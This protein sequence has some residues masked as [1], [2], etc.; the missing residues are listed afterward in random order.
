[1]TLDTP[2]GT[3]SS[4]E[5]ADTSLHPTPPSHH[6]FH[7]LDGLRGIAAFMVVLYHMPRF[8]C[9][10]AHTAFL[11]V[12]FFFCLSGFVIGFSY[13]KRLLAGM[14]MKDFFAARIIRLYPTYLLAILLSL[15]LLL[16]SL[17]YPLS[18]I[19]I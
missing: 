7:L 2:I 18:L 4:A 9:T 19:H 3:R 10:F 6:R 12:D 1:M 14:R 5:P 8:M 15:C 16:T 17:N 11:S 13:E